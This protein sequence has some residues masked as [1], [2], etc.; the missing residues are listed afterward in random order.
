V[1]GPAVEVIQAVNRSGNAVVAVDIPS[2]MDGNTGKPFGSCVRAELTVT[3]GFAKI[4]FRKHG[5]PAFTGKVFVA[6]IGYPARL[7][8]E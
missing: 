6:D 1:T 8:E 3:M 2:G 4:G 7:L 5:A